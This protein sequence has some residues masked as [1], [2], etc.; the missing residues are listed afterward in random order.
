[1][2]W[3]NEACFEFEPVLHVPN[4]FSPNSD[5]VN[6]S[7]TVISANIAVFEMSIFNRWGEMVFQTFDRY[8][9]WDGM[10]KGKPAPIDVYVVVIK[11]Q[12]NTPEMTYTGN[13]TII[14]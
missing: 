9:G 3:S 1:M 4:A 8:D 13:I 5:G 2:S 6:D 14:K 7:F 10:F 11:Y 12:G